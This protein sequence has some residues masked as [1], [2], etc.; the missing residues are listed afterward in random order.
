[1]RHRETEVPE[2]HEQAEAQASTR[3][4]ARDERGHLRP[5]ARDAGPRLERVVQGGRMRVFRRE[6][7]IGDEDF[8]AEPIAEPRRAPSIRRGRAHEETAPVQEQ[9]H[10]GRR[11]HGTDGLDGEA[12]GDMVLEDHVGEP[13]PDR[14]PRGATVTLEAGSHP[15][16]R[17]RGSEQRA[18]DQTV[19]PQRQ[20][21]HRRPQ[22]ASAPPLHPVPQATASGGATEPRSRPLP[23]ESIHVDDEIHGRRGV[24]EDGERR[25]RL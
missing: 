22:C 14:L 12:A 25:T 18:R 16:G 6:P 9:D 1:M 2:P 5:Q 23:E 24:V 21:A 7:V 15:R 11:R 17:R 19:G 13:A 3:R 4:V 10:P 8:R 20:P